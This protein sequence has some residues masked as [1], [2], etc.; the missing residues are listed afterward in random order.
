[1]FAQLHAVQ[2]DVSR[3]RIRRPR[4]SLDLVSGMD[5]SKP[6]HDREPLYGWDAP[7]AKTDQSVGE[8]RGYVLRLVVGHRRRADWLAHSALVY[9]PEVPELGGPTFCVVATTDCPAS[10]SPRVPLVMR[11]RASSR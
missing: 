7:D 9:A 6:V 3:D 10:G 5:G 8:V 2:R 1:M 11:T 4:E